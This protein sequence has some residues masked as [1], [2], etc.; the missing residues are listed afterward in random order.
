MT[1][2]DIQVS[3][4]TNFISERSDEK[5]NYFFFAYQVHIN[6]QSSETVQLMRRYWKITNASNQVQEVEGA[7]VIGQTPVLKP[8]EAFVYISA[9]PLDTPMGT[10]EG[11]YTMVDEYDQQIQVQIPLF[12][13]RHPQ[14]CH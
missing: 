5:Q 12:S 3:I 2:L 10:M 7:G 6:N 1:D 11:F 14:L 4:K 13:F 9:C 8:G